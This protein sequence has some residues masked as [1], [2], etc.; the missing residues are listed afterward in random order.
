M[1]LSVSNIAWDRERDEEM[2]AAMR[3]LGFT[4]LEVAPTR[5]LDMP[6]YDKI[7]EAAAFAKDVK[8]RYGLDIS[9]LQSI[10]FGRRENLF[11]SPQERG[12]LLDYTFRAIDFA[13]ACGCRNLVFGCPKNRNLRDAGQMPAAVEFFRALGDRAAKRGTVVALEANPASYGTNFINETR[14]AARLAERVASPGFRVNLDF[15]AMLE[16]GED[17]DSL[18]DCLHL[19]NHVHIS[20]PGLGPVAPREGHRKL[21]GLL[22]KG[23]Y[24]G[25]VSLE[26]KKTGDPRD[27]LSAMGYLRDVFGGAAP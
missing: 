11:G 16:N 24:A 13:S 25:Y 26:M 20:E 23:G 19:V 12:F 9:S 17:P 2:Y 10:W 6:V 15:G 21:A 8:M 27:V 5:I 4:G 3:E 22:E 7:G 1:R 18:A 14:Q